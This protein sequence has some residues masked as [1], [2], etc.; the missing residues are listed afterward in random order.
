MWQTNFLSWNKGFLTWLD[1]NDQGMR[2]PKKKKKKK[3]KRRK[4]LLTETNTLT[5]DETWGGGEGIDIKTKSRKQSQR[6]LNTDHCRGTKNPSCWQ[7]WTLQYSIPGHFQYC[8]LSVSRSPKNAIILHTLWK[9]RVKWAGFFL[10]S[11]IHEAKQPFIDMTRHFGK[12]EACFVT[13]R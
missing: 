11:F 9:L 12:C 10:F 2:A 5:C 7:S 4:E 3:K 1:L 8:I 6:Q 13:C